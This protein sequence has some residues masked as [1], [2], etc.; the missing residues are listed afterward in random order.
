M[1]HSTPVLAKHEFP[2]I[3]ITALAASHGC[4]S[5]HRKYIVDPDIL[6]I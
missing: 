4:G 3:A 5:Q 6:Y 1:P 2:L